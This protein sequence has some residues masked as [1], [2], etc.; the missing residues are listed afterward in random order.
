MHIVRKIVRILFFILFGAVLLIAG[1]ILALYS[2]WTQET[3]RRA[4]TE[5]FS[6]P[7]DVQICLESIRLRPPLRLELAG[8]DI[9]QHR[10]TVISAVGEKVDAEALAAYGIET[11]SRGCPDFKTNLENV[12]AGGDVFRGPATVV[13]GIADAAAFAEAVA[14]AKRRGKIPGRARASREAA[15]AKK[16]ILCESAKCEGDRC[17]SCNVVCQTCTDVC[18]NRANVVVKL[19]DGRAQ[20]LHVDRMCNECGNCLVFCPY[21]SAPYRDKFT[22][23]YDRAGFDESGSNQGFLPLGG[24]RVLVRL[25]GKVEEIDL[26]ETNDLP[27]GIE[28][29]IYTVL[30]R[31][32]YLLG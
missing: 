32:R 15:L 10:D 7:E 18:P 21:D 25:D 8:L 20:I 27:A 22:L 24:S 29:L 12:C 2:P 26:D 17:L 9:V 14:G 3:L 13:E 5:R 28:I 19:P 30:T 1:S 23:F 11:D 31:Y 16:G 6:D 4:V